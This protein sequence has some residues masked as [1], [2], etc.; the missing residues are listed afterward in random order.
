MDLIH[1]RNEFA[2]KSSVKQLKGSVSDCIRKMQ[3]EILYEIAFIES[4]LDD[5]EHI[6]TEGYPE[7]LLPK[8]Q[9]LLGRCEN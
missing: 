4:A 5:P 9:D 3:E 6:S 8:I 1:S 7:K 2:L